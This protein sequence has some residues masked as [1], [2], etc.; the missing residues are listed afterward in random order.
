MKWEVT[1]CQGFY[2]VYSSRS[3]YTSDAENLPVSYR[4]W[5][6][7]TK[8]TQKKT[9]KSCLYRVRIMHCSGKEISLDN[10]NIMEGLNGCQLV[11]IIVH[12]ET[13]LNTLQFV[14]LE[15]WYNAVRSFHNI[16]WLCVL[17]VITML[18]MF[19]LT[20]H[21]SCSYTTPCHSCSSF[22]L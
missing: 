17:N 15:R 4:I 11:I 13:L 1:G 7:N 9:E 22:P 12:F 3:S 18:G 14:L 20:Y 16:R 2:C 6:E 10:L 5:K 19:V 21:G 8:V